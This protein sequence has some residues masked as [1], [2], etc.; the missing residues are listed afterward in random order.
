MEWNRSDPS[1]ESDS[2]SSD[3][4]TR[5]LPA[6]KYEVFLSFR[7]PDVRTTF[8]DSLYH[9]LVHSKI[10]TFYDDEE[11]R[12]GDKI[13]PSLVRAIHESKIY[14]PILSQ[15]YAS[16]KWCLEELSLM[17]KSLNRNQGHIL[18]PV[19]YFVEPR[20]VRRQEGS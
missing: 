20:D 17:V 7:G 16:S 18:L 9:F 15:G 2:S 12:K 5:P 13:A 8:A 19:F 11:L 1:S 6:G 4:T 14:I 10:R 3:S